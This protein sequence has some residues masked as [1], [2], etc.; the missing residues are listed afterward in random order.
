MNSPELVEPC[1]SDAEKTGRRVLIAVHGVGAPGQGEILREIF[2]K[3]DSTQLGNYVRSDLMIRDMLVPRAVA[4]GPGLYGEIIDLNW[5]DIAWP[6]GGRLGALRHIAL[7]ILAMLRTQPT[8]PTA[9][10]VQS[11]A[12]RL[13]RAYFEGVFM[14]C[15]WPVLTSLLMWCALTDIYRLA[16]MTVIVAVLLAQTFWLRQYSALWPAGL[17]WTVGSLVVG[18]TIWRE[19][20]PLVVIIVTNIYSGVQVMTMFVLIG[21]VGAELWSHLRH[22]QS[23]SQAAANLSLLYLPIVAMTL[24]G[25]LLWFAALHVVTR[26]PLQSWVRLFEPALHYDLRTVETLGT[27]ATGSLPFFLAIGAIPYAVARRRTAAAGKAAQNWIALTLFIVPMVLAVP[28][29]VLVYSY[30]LGNVSPSA[31]PDNVVEV[32]RQSSVRVIPYVLAALIPLRPLFDVFG[33]VA[34]FVV[35]T[36]S[37][38]SVLPRA[39]E[40]LRTLL[41]HYSQSEVVI[42]AYSQGCVIALEA[43]RDQPRSALLVTVGSPIES[44]YHRF[45]GFQFAV[46]RPPR[47]WSWINMFR[48]GDYIAG[49]I[50]HADHNV[51]LKCDG[52]HLYYFA[53]P[54]V[55][56]TLRQ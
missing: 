30:F 18:V 54:E 41:S 52:G 9:R 2:S 46:E 20:A 43:L 25:T 56:H 39:V 23:L 5:N 10:D 24:V 8:R 45:L 51:T 33:D 48:P 36:D 1:S 7:L 6:K 3:P 4:T 38:L 15:I 29:V 53:D 42:V 27:L 40:R 32:Y 47:R 34:F 17:I 12:R 35:P 16:V 14:W 44:L 50:P 11:T 31:T 49:A 55:W 21:T 19:G 28:G 22:N 26:S 13:F 37:K